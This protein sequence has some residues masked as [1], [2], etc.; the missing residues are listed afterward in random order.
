M[1]DEQ[2][3]KA[4]LIDELNALRETLSTVSLP[5]SKENNWN[6]MLQHALEWKDFMLGLYEKS[7]HLNDAE[8]CRYVLDEVVRLTGSEIGFLHLVSDDQQSVI[9]TSWSDT[10]L[11]NCTAFHKTH[12]PLSEAGNWA[13]CLRQKRPVMCNDFVQS[14][15]QK[16]LPPGHNPI[17]RY[18]SVP[19]IEQG[20]VR[21][22]FSVANKPEDYKDADIFQIQLVVNGLQSILKR[23]QVEKQ[24]RESEE[25]LSLTLEATRD[26]IWDWNISEENVYTS[27]R[28]SRMLGYEPDEISPNSE[29]WWRL[30]HHEDKERVRQALDRIKKSNFVNQENAPA[31]EFRMRKKT[32]DW[33]WIL[34][35][36]KVVAWDTDGRPLRM[37]GTHT[38]ITERKKAE[39]ALRESE[40]RYRTLFETANDAILLLDRN[41]NYIECNSRATA[42]AGRS[43]E[44]IIGRK[45]H[46]N[47]P[48]MQS[49]GRGSEAAAREYVKEALAGRPQKFYWQYLRKDDVPIDID[50]SLNKLTLRNEE[51]LQVIARDI[52]EQ[53]KAE[54]ILRESEGKFKDLVEE[55]IVGIYLIQNDHFK[56]VNAKFA[57]IFGYGM[58]ELT[59]KMGPSDVVFADDMGLVQE[60]IHK[61]LIGEK[62]HIHYSFRILTKSGELRHVEVHSSNTQYQGKPAV[63]GMLLDVTEKI[64]AEESLRESENIFHTLF[65]KSG[66]AHLIMEEGR[67][68]DCNE[69]ALKVL[70]YSSKS[71]ILN[72]TPADISPEKQFDGSCS[73]EKCR[74]KSIKH[75]N[76]G[77]TVLIGCTK[78]LIV[79]R[80]TWILFL[81]QFY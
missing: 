3:T 32:G 35:R 28:Y 6:P 52:T 65:E 54:A 57:E 63:I 66:D 24:L 7:F 43:Y 77:Q 21:I 79:C 81:H 5:K 23:C 60:N 47:S 13:D 70:G 31:L 51:Y 38:D 73:A 67:F 4:Q 75:F 48:V 69:A 42:I 27:S 55:S 2:K 9:M 17:R 68:I 78:A 39:E 8:L 10:A 62:K 18:M 1:L 36:G 80:D 72:L 30:I 59:H 58:D 71:Q 22:I 12:Y 15:N 50:V 56:Y 11:K 14:L 74:L 25:R 44:E 29:A 41:L 64:R 53:R 33:C 34:A 40:E 19:V 16:G 76:M 61:R 45:P 49:D 37:V 26:G 20:K 46:D